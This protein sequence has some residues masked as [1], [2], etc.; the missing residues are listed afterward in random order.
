GCAR[1][2]V[3]LGRCPHRPRKHDE[4][5]RSR[6]PRP[7]LLPER[8]TFPHSAILPKPTSP[9]S[10]SRTGG[11]QK[12]N[13]SPGSVGSAGDSSLPVSLGSGGLASVLV[14]LARLGGTGSPFLIGSG[15]SSSGSRA[16]SVSSGSGTSP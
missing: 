11:V 5:G 2:R 12:S 6:E 8:A 4:F 13:S 10:R 14:F 9:T 15:C 3:G 16:S 1:C 7:Q